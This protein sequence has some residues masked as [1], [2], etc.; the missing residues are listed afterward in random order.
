[1]ALKTFIPCYPL[2]NY[3]QM[4]WYWEG[5][6]PPHTKERILP[7]GMM[8]I[9]INL[10]EIPFRIHDAQQD[11]NPL[12]I[13]ECLVSGARSTYFVIETSKP[14]SILSV[15]FKPGGALTLLGVNGN[16]IHNRHLPLETL[17]GQFAYELYGRLQEAQTANQYFRILEKALLQKLTT[18]SEQHRAVRYALRCFMQSP[19][20]VTI[21]KV[22]NAIAL[23]PTR[24]IQVFR[25][26]VG[27]SPKQ[28]CRVQRFQKSL[29]LIANRPTTNWVDVA[30]ACGYYDQSHFINDFRGFAGITPSHYAPQSPNHNTNLPLYDVS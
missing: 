12:E 20:S 13:K 9:T 6:H 16:E 23:S 24:F 5:Y 2:S 29:H 19:H 17:W 26:D 30:L 21:S 8:E 28:F 18:S 7:G 3:I 4:F 25:E 10:N 11:S 27:L 22:V 14:M 1:M 15:W